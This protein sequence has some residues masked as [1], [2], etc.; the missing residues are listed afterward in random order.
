MEMERINE[1]SKNIAQARDLLNTFCQ[2]YN[3][4]P[5]Q[6]KSAGD[7]LDKTLDILTTKNREK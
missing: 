5:V 4:V 6:L 7:L 1:S 3:N 2:N